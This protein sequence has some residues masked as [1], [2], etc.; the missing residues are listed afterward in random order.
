MKDKMFFLNIL[1]D[2][3]PIIIYFL[4]KLSYFF[5]MFSSDT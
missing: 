2:M 4:N 3:I 5:E 1:D